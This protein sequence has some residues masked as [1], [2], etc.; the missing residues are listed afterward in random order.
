MTFSNLVQI[1]HFL[2]STLAQSFYP[3]STNCDRRN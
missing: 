2:R 1:F 3:N